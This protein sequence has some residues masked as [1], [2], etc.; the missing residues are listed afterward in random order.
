ME[1]ANERDLEG[2]TEVTLLARCKVRP[3]AEV[4]HTTSLHGSTS[5]AAAAA[6]Q[7]SSTVGAALADPRCV[8]AA[9]ASALA[10]FA[11][12]LLLIALLAFLFPRLVAWSLAL[13]AAG[14]AAWLLQRALRLRMSAGS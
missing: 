7:A 4:P 10:F 13:F 1:Q 11:V 12:P 2:A 5:R 14:F 6:L 8:G 9:E 3:R